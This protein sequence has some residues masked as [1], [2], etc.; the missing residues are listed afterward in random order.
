MTKNHFTVQ[1]L[2]DIHLE[3]GIVPDAKYHYQWDD[4]ANWQLETL[5]Q[6]GIT[7][8]SKLLDIGC[9]SLRFGLRAI[10]FLES[11]NYFGIDAFENYIGIGKKLAKKA[12]P[13]KIYEVV[14]SNQFEFAKFNTI[15]D[16]ALAQ[17]V[18]THL[19]LSQ[20][21][22]CLKNLKLVLNQNGKFIFTY[23]TSQTPY[24]FLY[25]GI[26]PMRFGAKC[27]DT[28]LEFTCKQ[29]GLKFEKLNIEHPTGQNVGLIMQA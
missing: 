17:S 18:F 4:L 16:Y 2:I 7:A 3:A 24:G 10:D 27:N 12:L 13:N 29:Y 6:Q 14:L 22:L 23:I 21:E 25:F 1:E 19:S 9:G 8:N 5:K 15:F 28:F 20:I 26:E 11:G